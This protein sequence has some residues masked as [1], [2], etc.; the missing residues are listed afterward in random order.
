MLEAIIIGKAVELTGIWGVNQVLRIMKSPI[1]KKIQ[2]QMMIDIP[3][4]GHFVLCGRAERDISFSVDFTRPY[5]ATLNIMHI[6]YQIAYSSKVWYR[7]QWNGLVTL[8]KNTLRTRIQLLYRTLESLLGI[9]ESP[10]GWKLTGTATIKCVYGTF[11]KP[12]ESKIL[13]VTSDISWENLRLAD[14]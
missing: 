4:D 1:L 9:P 5:P 8:D 14:C 13:T 7:D 11:Q 10:S 12:F 2:S 3:T 6:D